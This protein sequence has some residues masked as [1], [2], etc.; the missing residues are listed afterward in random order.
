[1]SSN[2]INQMTQREWRELGFF[3]DRDDDTKE[4]RLQGSRAGLHKFASALRD[5]AAH[6]G[7]AALS[8]H[9]HLG[10]HYYLEIGTWSS[11]E[12]TDRWIAGP[13]PGL[14]EL[15]HSVD[16]CLVAASAGDCICLRAL[17]APSSSHE[18]VLQVKDDDFDPAAA[19]AACW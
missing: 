12:I 18:L 16:T 5:Y 6:P 4:W 2:K 10:P 3:Y 17:F 1:M 9:E 8:E 19:D 15:A 14:Q 7:H 13:L 11:P